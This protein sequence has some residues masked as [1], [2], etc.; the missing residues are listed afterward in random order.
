MSIDFTNNA[1]E[2]ETVITQDI[3]IRVLSTNSVDGIHEP[4]TREPDVHIEL[5]PL[6]QLKNISDRFTK[7]ALVA[8]ASS[9]SISGL[10]SL[11]PRLELSANM[12]GCLRVRILTDA[13]NITSTWTGLNNPQLDPA[14][15]GGEDGLRNHPSE[16]MRELGDPEGKGEEGWSRVHI[17]GR[18]WSKVMSVGRVG[19]RVIACRLPYRAFGTLHPANSY[20]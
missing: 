16:R 11:G 12:H 8:K 18:D 5:P 20:A 15:V 17:D 19:G 2:R 10:T 3:P 1:R 14:Q 7:L 6:I 13:M 4:R 9:S